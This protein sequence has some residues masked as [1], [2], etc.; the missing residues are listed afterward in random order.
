MNFSYQHQKYQS[1]RQVVYSNKGIVATSTPMAAEAG[2]AIIRKGGNAVDAAIATAA[3]LTVTEPTANGIGGDAFAIVWMKDRLYG[4]NSSGP[5]PSGISAETLLGQG[6]EEIP[7]E[8]FLPVTVPGVPAAWAALSKR[9]GRLSLTEVLAPAVQA[10]SEGYAVQPTVARVWKSEYERFLSY[11]DQEAFHPWFETFAPLDRAPA[12]GEVW[13]SAGHAATLKEI[14][15]TEAESF[16]RGDLAEKIDAFSRKYDGFLRKEDLSAFYPQWVE[17][18]STNYKGYQVYELPPNGQGLSVLM[19]LNIFETQNCQ[20]REDPLTIHR[21]IESMKL[22][23]EDAK[24]YISDPRHMK[25]TTE[26]L[27]RKEY[28]GKRAAL[29]HD[30]AILPAPGIPD[31][32][33]TV[34]LCTADGEGNMVSYIQSNFWEF[35]SGMVV[36]DTG[37][38]LQNRGLNFN[39]KP[40]H[41][42]CLEGGK[43]PYHTIIPGFLMKDGVPV[44][45]FGVMGGFMQPQGHLQVITNTIDFLLSPQDA[46]DAPRWQWTGGKRVLVEQGFP[47]WMVQELLARGHEI[48]I[49]GDPMEFG[50]GQIIWRTDLG[51]LCAGTESRCDGCA[52]IV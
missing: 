1:A 36:P 51:T 16:Y 21:M 25:Y 24:E 8:G 9:F 41:P 15:E 42:N 33:G 22:A 18:L 31:S 29:I 52:V 44:G 38:A 11:R 27:L 43:K 6:I 46:L 32:S 48:Q 3:M 49:C 37:I 12:T 39:L 13:K 50:R 7:A 30:Q 4:L 47:P 5:A 34:Y 40:G 23:Y 10:A 17:P 45:P 20:S 2:A 19:A 26:Q 14:G 35:G 28:A